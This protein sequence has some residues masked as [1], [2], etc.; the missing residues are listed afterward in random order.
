MITMH[1]KPKNIRLGAVIS[2][3]LLFLQTQVYGESQT[4]VS[5]NFMIVL[6]FFGSNSFLSE[7]YTSNNIKC[8]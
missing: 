5:S 2:L 1:I 7:V 3:C 4:L 6:I 8:L